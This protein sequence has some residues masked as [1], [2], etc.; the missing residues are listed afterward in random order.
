MIIS[1]SICQH[2][3]LIYDFYTLGTGDK[4]ECPQCE[5]SIYQKLQLISLKYKKLEAFILRSGTM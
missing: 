3:T 5:K 2:A 1:K 4:E